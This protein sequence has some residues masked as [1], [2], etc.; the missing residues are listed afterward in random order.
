MTS[1]GSRAIVGSVRP[2]CSSTHS[3]ASAA[4]AMRQRGDMAALDGRRATIGDPTVRQ[5]SLVPSN[6]S[7]EHGDSGRPLPRLCGASQVSD[8]RSGRVEPRIRDFCEHAPAIGSM[9][10][11]PPTF[12][13]VI[14]LWLLVTT[15]SRR[16]QQLDLP[17]DGLGLTARRHHQRDHSALQ[18][19]MRPLVIQDGYRRLVHDGR[20]LYTGFYMTQRNP[21]DAVPCVKAVFPM[22]GGNATVVLHPENEGAWFAS[23]LGGCGLW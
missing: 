10:G 18:I 13:P 7:V 22:P 14:P 16:V 4:A 23:D 17:L 21:R 12:R 19:R 15:I 6:L 20:V 9:H 3:F 8:F 2:S 5:R 11:A 1:H